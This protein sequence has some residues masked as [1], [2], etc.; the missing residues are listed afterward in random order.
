MPKFKVP[1]KWDLFTMEEVE[2]KDRNAAEHMAGMDIERP[3]AD[4]ST[5]RIEKRIDGIDWMEMDKM[6]PVPE[7]PDPMDGWGC[8][9]EPDGYNGGYWTKQVG[10][11]S[12]SVIGDTGPIEVGMGFTKYGWKISSESLPYMLESKVSFVDIEKCRDNALETLNN[13]KKS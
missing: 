9:Y 13:L 2:A 11:Y 4:P 5:W 1:M 6:Y 3:R 12:V 10:E 8:L 7:P